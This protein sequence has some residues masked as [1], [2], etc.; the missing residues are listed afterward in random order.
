MKKSLLPCTR[1]IWIINVVEMIHELSTTALIWNS[2]IKLSVSMS[3]LQIQNTM[4]CF[5]RV[6]E[7]FLPTCSFQVSWS[8]SEWSISYLYGKRG[9][10]TAY[11]VLKKSEATG[12]KIINR[13][14]NSKWFVFWLNVQ[15]SFDLLCNT[16]LKT[17]FN[18]CSLNSEKIK[19][20]KNW[21]QDTSS[22][23]RN[24]W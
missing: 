3:S 19:K 21:A 5:V 12:T 16:E 22:Q 15:K 6:H 11:L 24:V 2:V 9:V 20:C 8:E 4:Q 13:M 18:R 7:Y 10:A 23:S 14:R 1:T 17:V